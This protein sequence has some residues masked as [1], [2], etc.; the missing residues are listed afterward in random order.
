[1]EIDFN[2]LFND[3]YGF[4]LTSEDD[5]YECFYTKFTDASPII[6]E[7]F[8]NTDMV[9]QKLMLRK[10]V[11]YMVNFFVTKKAREHFVSIACLH[12]DKLQIDP[13]LYE[14]FIDTLLATLAEFYPRYN[15]AVGVSWR[16]TLAPGVEF[17]KHISKLD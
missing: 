11:S 9:N 2:E 10:A 16:I 8:R 3:S 5:F 6:A 12:K 14:I 13:I 15:N 1:M 7:V 4:I 17:M